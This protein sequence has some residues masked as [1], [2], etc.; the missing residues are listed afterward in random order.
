MEIQFYGANCVRL[1]TKKASIVVDDLTGNVTKPGDIVLFTG[2]H[3]ETKAEP[4]IVIEQ[5]GEYEVSD[6]SIQ[7]V[8]AR[9]HMDP[10]GKQ[11]NTIFKVVGDDLKVVILGHVYPEISDE[12]LEALGTTDVLIVP[13]GGH[14]YTLDAVGALHL[15][16][17]IEPKIIIPTHYADKAVTYEV[18][19]A[20]LEEALKELSMEPKETVPKLKLKSTELL[21]ENNQ[22]FILERQ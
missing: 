9:G 13:V 21:G 22:L 12:Q 4:K 2:E 6:T 1:T 3:A 15:I 14:G 8:G 10:E 5:P 20:T 17:E 7:G 11:S 18:P 19:Q 16:K